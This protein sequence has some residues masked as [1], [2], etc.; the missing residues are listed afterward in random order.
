MHI[1]PIKLLPLSLIDPPENAMRIE[2]D[3]DG[4]AELCRGIVKV[5]G[6]L[7]P[8]AVKQTNGRFEIVAGH[9][10]YV[11][12]KRL[13]KDEIETRDWTDGPCDP[14]TIKA[15]E[16]FSQAPLTDIEACEWLAT[17]RDKFDADLATLM[18]M[19]GKSENWIAQRLN[20]YRGDK[21]VYEALLAGEV[22]IAVASVLNKFPPDYLL[23]HLEHAK[24]SGCSA[25]VV[26]GWLRD[27]KLQ[28]LP[29]IPEDAP[30]SAVTNQTAPHLVGP[31]PCGLCDQPHSPWDMTFIQVHKGC[32][33]T[34]KKA[35]TNHE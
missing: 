29:P 21:R 10:R 9:R 31:Q 17:M 7:H 28:N 22:S 26:E 23:M 3:E 4:L 16:N 1:P 30:P 14:E 6:L 27:V 15:I 34:L 18:S 5:G 32:F 13:G 35:I 8:I 20:I 24:Q 33:E 19:T 12:Y 2:M 25:K 11:A